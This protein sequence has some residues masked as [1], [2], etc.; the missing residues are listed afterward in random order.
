MDLSIVVL[1]YNTKYLTLKCIESLEKVFSKEL[2]DERVEIILV[3]N[4]SSD[5]SVKEF[6][7][8][9]SIVLIK[10]KEN[11]GFGKGN[12]IGAL[13]AKG[14]YV[15]FLNSDTEVLDKGFLEMI[16]F[17]R[18]NDNVGILGGKLFFPDGKIQK[19]TGNF[20]NLI[21][22]SLMLLGIEKRESPK[23]IKEVDWVSGACMMI[24]KELFE[25]LKGFDENIFM[26]MEDVEICYRSKRL[27]FNTY[28]YPG[29]KVL[30]KE[31]ASSNKSFAI[32]NIY[33]GVDYFYK[34]H[35][36]S[37][38]HFVAKTLLI[39][40]ALIAIIYGSLISDKDLV[41]TYKTALKF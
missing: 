16:N 23:K 6:E 12:N 36:S 15:I 33:K 40:K 38:E 32:L 13:K 41:K 19:S 4:N 31:R 21:G 26:Y 20:Y 18:E 22:L 17:M 24:R 39:K 30:H 7:K 29:V 28:F 34:K 8:H 5:G 3:D 2:K 37:T 9:K 14:E 35:K 10:N 1:N 27:G 11:Y 25:K